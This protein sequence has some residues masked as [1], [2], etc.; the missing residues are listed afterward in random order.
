MGNVCLWGIC[1]WE[2]VCEEFAVGNVCLWGI[3]SWECVCE[4]F[5]V[6]NV[7]GHLQLVMCL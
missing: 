2:C 4:E 7:W 5:A 1:S 3:C 6:G